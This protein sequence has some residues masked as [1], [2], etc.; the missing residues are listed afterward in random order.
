MPVTTAS[1]LPAF[2][3]VFNVVGTIAS[4]R[5]TGRMDAR[6]L[7]AGCLSCGAC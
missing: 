7:L 1:A 4:G 5:L 6:R 3:G 2:I